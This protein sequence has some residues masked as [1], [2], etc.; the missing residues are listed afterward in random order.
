MQ[1]AAERD[2][3][4]MDIEQVTKSFERDMKT[5]EVEKQSL[6][7]KI[8]TLQNELSISTGFV[9]EYV[10]QIKE[11]NARMTEMETEMKNKLE[12]KDK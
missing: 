3:I 6:E 10:V 4:K 2:T 8:K 1:I 7:R 9:E 5:I 12:Q 11:L